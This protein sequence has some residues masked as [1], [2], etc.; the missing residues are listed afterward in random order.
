MFLNARRSENV[1]R[2]TGHRRGRIPVEYPLMLDIDLETPQVTPAAWMLYKIYV[3]QDI[4][5]I[6]NPVSN[7][8]H[9]EMIA[10]GST[11]TAQADLQN[12]L[13]FQRGWR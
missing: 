3:L 12:D 1:F 11:P 2:S 13:S 4:W 5:V 10:N 6:K 8:V 7:S 9:R